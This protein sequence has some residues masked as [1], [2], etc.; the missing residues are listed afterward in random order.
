MRRMATTTAT[1]ARLTGWPEWE[2]TNYLSNITPQKGA[3]NQGPWKK[4]EDAVR[5]AVRAG[6]AP[7][8]IVFTGPL[9]EREM[10]ALPKSDEAHTVP[11]GY[12]KLVVLD[13]AGGRA[14][15][16]FVMDQAMARKDDR[17]AVEREAMIERSIVARLALG[18]A[19]G[20]ELASA[21]N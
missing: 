7:R 15:A 18:R 8:A 11:S 1:K 6:K 10:P 16:G 12:W 17:C 4:L 3:L 21:A 20:P 14:A 9:Y 13:M 19:V 2:K 5:A